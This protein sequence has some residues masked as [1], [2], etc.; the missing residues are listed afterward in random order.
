MRL[1]DGRRKPGERSW[2]AKKITESGESAEWYS[3]IA[4]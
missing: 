3:E 2:N 4:L 1:I